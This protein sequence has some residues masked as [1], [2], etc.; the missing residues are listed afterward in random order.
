M[1]NR[2]QNE[3]RNF[4]KGAAAAVA[5]GVVPFASSVAE[6]KSDHHWDMEADVVVVGSGVAA[7]SAA[8]FAN[9]SG[10]S[11]IVLEK[12]SILGGTSRKAAGM[13][14][15][16]NN[17]LMKQL[18]IAD[19]RDD[20]I[21]YMVR[22]AYPLQY[23]P[24]DSRLGVGENE[25]NVIAAIYDNGPKAVTELIEMGALKVIPWRFP[26]GNLIPDAYAHLPEDKAPRGRSLM[27]DGGTFNGAELIRQLQAV[28]ERLKIKVQTRHKVLHALKNGKNEVI[29]V[30]TKDEE[31]DKI[32]K[33]RARKAVIFGTGGFAQNVSLCENF[34]RGPIYGSCSSP[35]ST[36]DFVNIGLETGAGLGNMNH[37]GW[38]QIPLESALNV[39]STPIIMIGTPGDSTLTVNKYG[40]RVVNEK[41]SYNERPQVHFD[42]DPVR[43]E[44]H[45]LALF[46]I[47]DQRTAD[48]YS[49]IYPLPDD[50]TKAG[51]DVISGANLTEIAVKLEERLE[52][53][54]GKIGGL[55]LDASFSANLS[56]TVKRFNGYAKTGKDADFNRGD[57]PV[58]NAFQYW[59][60]KKV[61]N[62]FPNVTMYP[63]SETGPYY[64][65]LL[66]PGA[67]D[68]KGGPRVNA[69]GQVMDPWGKPIAG[70]YGVGTCVAHPS[71]QGYWASGS[72][73]GPGLAMGYA[74]GRNAAKET[75]KGI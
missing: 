40:R 18:G 5:T 58:Q 17:P 3:R 47:F 69:K 41:A 26:D 31:N 62:E 53:L 74:A 67:F 48:L 12:Q 20:A 21:R 65:M 22:V 75:V 30:E 4:I 25:Y 72:S 33:I 46:M 11:V 23:N 9:K 38:G 45:N 35:G 1:T 39:R 16:P 34:L 49:G 6:A 15:V 37:A 24:K 63:I 71:G 64:A 55:K 43:G 56:E 57:A 54:S 66:G 60:A 59:G 14:W 2:K 44:Y 10:A 32:I 52:M 19:Q 36:G 42:W 13:I 28:F 61:T 7:S 50:I 70:L 27:A 73:L 29:G 8:L 68:T 51:D